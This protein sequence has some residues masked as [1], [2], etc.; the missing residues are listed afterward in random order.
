VTVIK[1]LRVVRGLEALEV[2]RAKTV[3]VGS[4][5]FKDLLDLE[6]F[7]VFLVKMGLS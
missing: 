5:V 4:R 1:G 2:K 6:A 7:K 3:L